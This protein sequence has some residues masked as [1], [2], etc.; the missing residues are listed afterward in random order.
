[1]EGEDNGLVSCE[2]AIE[3]PIRE[4]V[5]VFGGGNEPVKIHH[6]D[7]PDFEIGKVL[8]QQRYGC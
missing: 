4:A 5:G 2:Q 7:E 1:M 8:T 6:V 3:V